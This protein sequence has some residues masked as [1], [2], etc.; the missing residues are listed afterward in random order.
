MSN[1]K[2]ARGRLYPE[3]EKAKKTLSEEGTY[4]TVIK[5]EN[6]H[7]DTELDLEITLDEFDELA[8]EVLERLKEPLDK[9]LEDGGFEKDE[10]DDVLIVG[11]STRIPKVRD[12]LS[13]YFDGKEL[14]CEVH[15]D[16]AVAE[17]ATLMARQLA[18]DPKK[19]K[20]K[21]KKGASKPRPSESALPDAA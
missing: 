4:S 6:F 5:L 21:G 20:G 8:A 9:A 3:C 14:N 17:G 2:R 15:A 16:E 10:I 13:E 7:E 1:D 19:S 18:S 12:W 11:G